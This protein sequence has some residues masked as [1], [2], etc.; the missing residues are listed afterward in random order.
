MPRTFNIGPALELNRLRNKVPVATLTASATAAIPR[1]AAKTK[2]STFNTQRSA[3]L[4][5]V[6]KENIAAALPKK[7]KTEFGSAARFGYGFLIFL[8]ILGDLGD[9]GI[10]FAGVGELVSMAFDGVLI[11]I[12]IYFLGMNPKQKRAEKGVL[13]KL[14]VRFGFVEFI[15]I[16]SIFNLRSVYVYKMYK[17]RIK[18]H[19]EAM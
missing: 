2:T 8:N 7:E 14:L 5:K 4:R 12:N 17:Q 15:P 18:L 3:Q 13:G 1:V 11:C 9:L 10:F 19:E 16:I 6:Q